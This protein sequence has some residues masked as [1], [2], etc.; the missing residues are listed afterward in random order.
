MQEIMADPKRPLPPAS[1]RDAE[2]AAVVASPTPRIARTDASVS[3]VGTFFAAGQSDDGRY[4]VAAQAP[5]S[6]FAAGQSE[7]D[8]HRA[9]T[10]PVSQRRA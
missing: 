6:S 1:N 9:P 5:Q 7:Q 2:V 10:D 3:T 8:P 4:V